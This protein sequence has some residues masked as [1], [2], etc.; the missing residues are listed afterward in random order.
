MSETTPKRDVGQTSDRHPEKLVRRVLEE[1]RKVLVEKARLLSEGI[2]VEYYTEQLCMRIR[3]TVKQL[4][5]KAPIAVKRAAKQA[6]ESAVIAF[7]L[8]GQA[9]LESHL[10]HA[11]PIVMNLN[12][13]EAKAEAKA[14]AE[15]DLKPLAQ[16]LERLIEELTIIRNL[17][18][19]PSTTNA[20]SIID[21]A[22]ALLRQ[23]VKEKD[24]IERFLTN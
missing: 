19:Y 17:A 8:G 3:P 4:Y 5:L 23:L 24:R 2:I 14:K 13:V 1:E 11:A 7:Y 6:L 15:V 12:I 18:K 16:L 20:R 10:S 9:S 22:E 21:K